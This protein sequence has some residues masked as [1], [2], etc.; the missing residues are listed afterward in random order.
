FADRTFVPSCAMY[1]D[2]SKIKQIKLLSSSSYLFEEGGH[3]YQ[4]IRGVGSTNAAYVDEF[5]KAEEEKK[6]RDHR[7]IGKQLEIFTLDPL[8]GQGLPI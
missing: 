8:I 6:K 5:F 3:T 7:Y 2:C 4:L 1:E